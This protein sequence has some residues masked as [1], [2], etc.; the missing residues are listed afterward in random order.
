M[1]ATVSRFPARN[2]FRAPLPLY[3]ELKERTDID[4]CVKKQQSENSTL[5]KDDAKKACVA[6]DK[7]A[8]PSH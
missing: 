5:S 1:F 3:L 6:Q 7:A 2:R 8:E 4:N